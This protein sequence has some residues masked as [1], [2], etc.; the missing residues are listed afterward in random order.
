MR[1]TSQQALLALTALALG[2]CEK[3]PPPPPPRPPRPA[4]L[5]FVPKVQRSIVVDTTGTEDAERVTLVVPVSGDSVAQFYRGR[6]PPLG[7]RIRNDRASGAVIDL[8]L[9]GGPV[10]SSL[11]VHIERQDTASARYTLIANSPQSR[12]AVDTVR[13]R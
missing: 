8:Y 13:T 11:W 4:V 2:A 7:W 3:A 5:I 10:G 12:P 6:L 9:E 1:I